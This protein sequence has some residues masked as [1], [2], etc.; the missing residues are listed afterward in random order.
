MALYRTSHSR[1]PTAG[2][3]TEFRPLLFGTLLMLLM[4]AVLWAQSPL[5][6]ELHMI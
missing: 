3:R 1:A 5:A 6:V 2:Y 4:V